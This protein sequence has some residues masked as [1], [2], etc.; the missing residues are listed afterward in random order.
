MVVTIDNAGRLV[1]PKA[2]RER[3]NLTPGCELEIE[4]AANGI[5]L[6]R[7]DEEPTLVRKQGI[8]VHHGSTHASVDIGEFVRAERKARAARI[9]RD[10][11]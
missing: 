4:P 3:F 9:A 11:G 2:L 8:L 10:I 5:T 6:R 7:V 1:V